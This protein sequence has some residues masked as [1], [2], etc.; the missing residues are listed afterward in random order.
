MHNYEV[1]FDEHANCWELCAVDT[2][3]AQ[4]IAAYDTP[5]EAIT[6]S[7]EIC[8]DAAMNCG[9]I[10]LTVRSI[11]GSALCERTFTA[12]PVAPLQ[13]APFAAKPGSDIAAD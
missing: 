8:A 5:E 2:A 11:D 10:N 9:T 4:R 3:P 7:A 13:L 12:A 6:G 1:R